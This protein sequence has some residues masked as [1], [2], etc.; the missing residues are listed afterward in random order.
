MHYREAEEL[1]GLYPRWSDFISLRDRLDP[2]RTF[3][4]GYTDTVFGK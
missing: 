3:S 1:S 2:Q 4:N